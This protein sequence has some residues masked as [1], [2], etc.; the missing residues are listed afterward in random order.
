MSQV[1]LEVNA[2]EVAAKLTPHRHLNAQKHSSVAHSSVKT[3]SY[4]SG[5]TLKVR[6][7]HI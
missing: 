4:V 5:T 1:A 2:G 6:W 3:S 7:Q